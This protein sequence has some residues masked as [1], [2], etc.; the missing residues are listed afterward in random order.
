MAA[1]I[2]PESESTKCSAA[3]S[4]E[5]VSTHSRS[6]SMSTRR[7]AS[8][9]QSARRLRIVMRQRAWFV[10]KRS[11]VND[12]SWVELASIRTVCQESSLKI[13]IMPFWPSLSRVR[14]KS[15]LTHFGVLDSTRMRDI[16]TEAVNAALTKFTLTV[17]TTMVMPSTTLCMK[18]YLP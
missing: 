13:N 17:F 9:V 2:N 14:R 3:F 5:S 4:C 6:S 1:F 16:C 15:A 7:D 10:S 8:N 11:G 18:L 12:L